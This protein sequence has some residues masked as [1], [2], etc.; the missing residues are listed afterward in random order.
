M[1]QPSL[2]DITDINYLLSRPPS[3][4]LRHSHVAEFH[5]RDTTSKRRIKPAPVSAIEKLSSV[6]GSEIRQSEL[7]SL[8]SPVFAQILGRPTRSECRL[9]EANEAAFEAHRSEIIS[10][11]DNPAVV[12][13]V[14]RIALRNRT[15]LA[16]REAVLMAALKIS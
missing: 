11:L 7:L 8:R 14:T 12:T 16:E 4:P 1:E 13:E 15:K 3:I 9:K 6:I 5:H 10:I 2:I